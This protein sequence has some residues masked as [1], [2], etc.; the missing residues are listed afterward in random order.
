LKP[1]N[2]DSEFLVIQ[3]EGV[4]FSNKALQAILQEVLTRGQSVRLGVRGFSMFPCI[5]DNDIVTVS[6]L[7]GRVSYLGLAVA[8]IHPCSNKLVIHRVIRQ[9]QDAAVIKG[10]SLFGIDGFIPLK[11]IL[12]AVTKIE[13]DNRRVRFGIGYGVPLAL[14]FN[15]TNLFAAFFH[16]GMRLPSVIRQAIKPILFR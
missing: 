16:L 4:A 10:D 2:P 14:F 6:P 13:R 11:N 8:F 1:E 7:N 5:M 9:D 3:E 15:K 12:G